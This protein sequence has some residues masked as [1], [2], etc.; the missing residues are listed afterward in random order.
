MNVTKS[1]ITIIIPDEE[2][3]RIALERL[4]GEPKQLTVALARA[5]RIGEAWEGQGGI[6][7]GVVAGRDG[8]PDYHLIVG[9]EH[10]GPLDWENANS[11]A[12]G[13]KLHGFS[14]YTLPYLKEQS[15]EFGNVGHLFKSESYWSREQ[16]A[17]GSHD[18]WGQYFGD[19]YQ[20]HWDKDDKFRARA[21]RRLV[22]Q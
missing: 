17:S 5:P 21:A 16:P 3:I 10:D 8:T 19:G 14:D 7:A 18:A 12:T 4:N 1:G 13:L 22:I 15:I 6:Y 11:W 20:R 9:P 2:V